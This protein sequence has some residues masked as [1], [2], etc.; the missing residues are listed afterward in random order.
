MTGAQLPSKIPPH[1]YLLMQEWQKELEAE[2]KL[3]HH[4]YEIVDEN[5]KMEFINGMIIFNSPVK[6][7]HS[8]ATGRIFSLISSYVEYLEL[9]WTGVE[10]VLVSLTRNDYEPDVCFWKKETADTFEEEQMHFP[11]PDFVVEVLSKKTAKIDR[12]IK[13]VDYEAHGVSEYWIVE[14]V[15]K[16][17]EQYILINGNYHL[18]FKGIAGTIK[19]EAIAGFEIEVEDIFSNTPVLKLLKYLLK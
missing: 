10:K 9:G 13:F 8:V 15:K 19:S 11:A 1:A 14:P 7:V 16:V 4:F 3:R 18:R 6:K 2:Q 12:T 5:S 17:I